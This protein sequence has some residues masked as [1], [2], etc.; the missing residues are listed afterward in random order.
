M[1]KVTDLGKEEVIHCKTQEEF[2]KI[3]A[4]TPNNTVPNKSWG[5]HKSET[6]YWPFIFGGTGAC[7]FLENA[8]N[9]DYKI[10]PASDFLEPQERYFKYVGDGEGNLT[11]APEVECNLKFCPEVGKVYP[12]NKPLW[13]LYEKSPTI[14]KEADCS[15]MNDAV[16][17]FPEEWEEV[18]E[19]EYNRQQASKS[20][21]NTTLLELIEDIPAKEAKYIVDRLQKLV[22]DK[23]EQNDNLDKLDN[24][25]SKL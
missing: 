17:D 11:Y 20:M 16:N 8:N 14:W 24:Y 22:Y 10:Y 13:S 15:V 3:L 19:E 23:T 9:K 6:Y 7:C 25:I 18:S 2:D 5:I 1:K 4:L 12:G 21:A